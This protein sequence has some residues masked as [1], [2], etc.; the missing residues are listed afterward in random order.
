LSIEGQVHAA[1]HGNV[2]RCDKKDAHFG[3]MLIY[4]FR[5]AQDRTETGFLLRGAE[6][7]LD[8]THGGKGFTKI[9]RFI[10]HATQIW[11]SV[12]ENY[13]EWWGWSKE[14]Q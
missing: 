9:P 2:L 8:A 11:D 12:P 14:N 6:A 1:G 3:L 10:R 4:Q 7:F 13:E 5:Q